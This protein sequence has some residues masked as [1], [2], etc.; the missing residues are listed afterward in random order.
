MYKEEVLLSVIIPFRCESSG[1]YYLIDRL[2]E[3]VKTFPKNLPIEFMVV[4]SGSKSI[5]REKCI[6]ICSDNNVRYLFHNTVGQP[7]SIGGCRDYGVEHA[8]GKA[9]T[10]LDVDL[11]MA[12]DFWLRLLDLMNSWG[13]SKYKKSFLAIPCLYLTQEGSVEF[14]EQDSNSHRFLSFY[15]RY[16]QGD[17]SAVENFAPCSSVMIVD[18]NHYLS[19]GGH[20]IDFRGHG[21]EDFEFYHRL[22]C[23]EGV[24]PK[25]D[26]YYLDQKSWKTFTYKG[27]RSHLAV[28]GRPAMMMGLFVVHLWHPRPKEASFY[29]KERLAANRNIW[30]DK[31]KAFE[32]TRINP[33][34]LIDK[35]GS[36]ENIL[37]F[38]KSHR[39]PS[40]RSLR[41]LLPSLGKAIYVDE[42]NFID[43][44][45]DLETESFCE[46]LRQYNIKRIVFPNPYGNSARLEIYKWCKKTNFPFYCYDR[47]AL[48]DSWFLDSKGFNYDSDSYIESCWDMKLSIEEEYEVDTYIQKVIH[49][50]NLLEKQFK[51]IGGE[52][53]GSKLD[54]GSKK[55][56]FVP[57][58]RPSD[59]VIKYMSGDVYSFNNFVKIIDKLAEK[60]KSVGWVVLCKKHPL[61]VDMPVL[62]HAKYVDH[63]T[64]FLDLLELADSVA[65]INSGVGVYAMMMGKPCYIF[66]DAFYQ[67]NGVNQ[68]IAVLDVNNEE[69][70]SN[71]AST[72]TSSF[73]VDLCKMKSFI[74]YLINNFYSFGT[75]NTSITK[76]SDGSLRSITNNIDFYEFRLDGELIFSYE[77]YARPEVPLW[78]PIFERYALDIHMKRQGNKQHSH[79]QVKAPKSTEKK[80]N[81]TKKK[82]SENNKVLNHLATIKDVKKKSKVKAKY[83]KFK[84]DPYRF[85]AD[86]K[87]PLGR[88]LR[89]L[90]KR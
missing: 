71:L 89:F 1:S 36:H 20:D 79:T 11:R 28:V 18:R 86:A 72:V 80:S 3:L 60:L 68:N 33:E 51:R 31:F 55:V 9:V 50:D 83:R 19:L 26:N 88:S 81:V 66:G 2:N 84:R 4:D 40:A 49:G 63:N 35:A 7:F 77:Q 67:I 22:L 34:P 42:N 48:P 32:E 74:H 13:I 16:L 17:T 76:E 58:Q 57:F 39:S 85:F 64:N 23:E 41:D 90:Y 6:E 43:R 24:I 38:S 47:G 59:T 82:N 78:A 12:D 87:N 14:L 29:S 46:L 25:P 27:F 53:L 15:L 8:R 45:G 61:E 21:Y 5:Y 54:L 56:L 37:F 10:F 62:K 44:Y 52:A 70:I 75:P 69:E 65:L 30:V 73:E